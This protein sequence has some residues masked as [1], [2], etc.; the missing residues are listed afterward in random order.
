MNKH[1]PIRWVGGDICGHLAP[2][3]ASAWSVVL[4]SS[5]MS[6]AGIGALAC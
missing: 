4:S 6:V 5:K 1:R 2:S 3:T